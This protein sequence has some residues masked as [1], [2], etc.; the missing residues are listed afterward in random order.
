MKISAIV[1]IVSVVSESEVLVIFVSA[2]GE[3][4]T[5]KNFGMV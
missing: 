3:S 2:D 1:K 4:T 5:S